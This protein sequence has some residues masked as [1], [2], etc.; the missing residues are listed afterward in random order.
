MSDTD[1]T[2]KKGIRQK[3]LEEAIRG[4][5]SDWDGDFDVDVEEE[6]HYRGHGYFSC[7]VSHDRLG[8]GASFSAR[9]ANDG[10][11]EMDMTGYDSWVPLNMGHLFALMWFK[12]KLRRY[13]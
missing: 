8:D 5:L 10:D 4:C 9:V 6:E 3:A 2:L 7:V 13:A 12:A 11:C 1:T